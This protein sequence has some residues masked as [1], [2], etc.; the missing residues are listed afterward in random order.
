[1]K[2]FTF[3]VMTFNQ[4]DFILQHLESIK[5]QIMAWGKGRAIHLIVSD[6][7]SHDETLSLAQEW[8]WD[9]EKL[10]ASTQFLTVK[11]N[12][13]IVQNYLRTLHAVQTEQFKILA[14]DDIYYKND[15]FTAAQA[16]SFV[17]SPV[18]Y[19]RDNCILKG[20]YK[21]RHWVFQE[22]V[23]HDGKDLKRQICKRQG[24]NGCICTPGV[25]YKRNLADAQVDELL[26]GHYW[27]EDYPLWNYILTRED[28]SPTLVY[29]PL[30]LYRT[31][32][33]VSTW[34]KHKRRAAYLQEYIA[35]LGE[36]GSP[37]ARY[38]LWLNPYRYLYYVLYFAKGLVYG[39]FVRSR[40][41]RVDGFL[42][43]IRQEEQRAA[44]YLHDICEQANQWKEKNGRHSG[45]ET[46]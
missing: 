15:I 18:L 4:A 42:R 1:M 11:S 5:Y 19:F 9:H 35:F 36:I 13:G 46:Q 34:T 28:V 26:K 31:N 29:D 3:A 38:P 14:G 12:Q 25:F 39:L 8:V 33:G 44:E 2:D 45:E 23:H 41:A 40:D 32:T 20:Q 27:M 6:D 7:G 37:F 17:L 24:I 22:F 43:A 30:V 21:L 10:F 16:G